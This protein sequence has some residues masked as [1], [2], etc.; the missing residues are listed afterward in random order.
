MPQAQT[1]TIRTQ[2]ETNLAERL[3]GL[4]VILKLVP[5]STKD[6]YLIIGRKEL[7]ERIKDLENL[8]ISISKPKA[9]Q[10]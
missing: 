2:I 3:K 8:E 6:K 10:Q 5:S 4:R 7:K 9:S 1:N